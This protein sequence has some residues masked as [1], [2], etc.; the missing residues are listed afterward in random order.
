[1]R[2]IFI[3]K[4]V[5]LAENILRGFGNQALIDDNEFFVGLAFLQDLPQLKGVGILSA[6]GR[7][8]F[9][10]AKN[11]KL[12]FSEGDTLIPAFLAL[13]KN[14][15]AQTKAELQEEKRQKNTKKDQAKLLFPGYVGHELVNNSGWDYRGLG[16]RQ[17]HSSKKF[18]RASPKNRGNPRENKL[19][20]FA[21][22]E[23]FD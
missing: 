23:P 18:P 13:R 14:P 1:V 6:E 2:L 20:F 22:D 5:Q 10:Q 21:V 19:F 11:A 17:G 8:G 16:Y 3:Q 15:T 9:A 12:I 7:G 4:I